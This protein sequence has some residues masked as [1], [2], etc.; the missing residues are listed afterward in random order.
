MKFIGKRSHINKNKEE[1]R[2]KNIS[3]D[4]IMQLDQRI[5]KQG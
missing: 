2:M 5:M 1:Q 3:N 4:Q